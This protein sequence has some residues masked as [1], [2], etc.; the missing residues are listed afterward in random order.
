MYN[1]SLKGYLA[2]ILSGVIQENDEL[3]LLS[4]TIHYNFHPSNLEFFDFTKY[5]TNK[6]DGKKNLTKTVVNKVLESIKVI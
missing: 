2:S 1:T 3:S 4:K 5:S 6:N